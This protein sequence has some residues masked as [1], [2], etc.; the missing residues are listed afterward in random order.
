MTGEEIYLITGVTGF[1]GHAVAEKL[2]EQGKSVVGLRLPGDRTR[3]PEGMDY[4][5]GDITKAHTLEKFFAQAADKK[6]V[7][8]HCA[9]LVS[10]ASREDA[11]WK[12]NVDGTR[13]IV[14]LC[15]K[16]GIAK[17][18]YVSSVHA[19][20]EKE[21]GQV[22]CETERFSASL[23]KG[24][25]GKSK[26]EA[27]NYVLRAAKKGLDAVVVHPSG[28][29]GPGGGFNGYM[30]E[31][32]RLY[33]KGCFPM[34]VEG[35]YDFVDVRDA[36]DGIVSCA[37]KG[38][39]GETYI[40]SGEYISVKQM[41]DLLGDITGKKKVYG[42]VPLKVVRR[43][44]PF[45]EKLCVA[46]QFPLLVTPYSVYTLGSNGSFSYEKAAKELGYEPRPIRETLADIA[47]GMAP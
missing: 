2:L 30:A 45:C 38:R 33:L 24:I 6:A 42:S 20:P 8:I 29:I 44:A 22:I 35:G 36:A 19:I 21:K 18:V 43:L 11:L 4:Q 23:V 37:E 26:A 34:A 47:E 16:H 46:M 17:L 13:N 12:V 7:L 25:Y 28:I 40:L 1:L 41:F 31:T 9:G 5:A 27:T 39:R 32:I 14:D 15:E 3:L 10:I